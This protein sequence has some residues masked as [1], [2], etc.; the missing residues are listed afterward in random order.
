[1]V[2]NIYSL[3]KIDRLIADE[4]MQQVCRM[5]NDINKNKERVETQQIKQKKQKRVRLNFDAKE[6]KSGSGGIIKKRKKSVYIMSQDRNIPW[7]RR[8]DT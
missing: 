8:Q 3:R 5:K 6:S 1:M 4:W 2:D 7:E